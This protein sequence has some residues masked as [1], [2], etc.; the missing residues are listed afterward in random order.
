RLAPKGGRMRLSDWSGFTRSRANLLRAERAI[1]PV[2]CSRDAL[3]TSHRLVL[4]KQPRDVGLFGNLGLDQHREVGERLLPAEVARF[5][6]NHVRHA[7]LRD[8][9]LGAA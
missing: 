4:L 5:G 2:F 3:G 7:L 1:A 6:G 9:Q 8:V